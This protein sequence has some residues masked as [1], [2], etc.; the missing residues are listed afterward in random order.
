MISFHMRPDPDQSRSVPYSQ[1]APGRGTGTSD[2]N[3]MRTRAVLARRGRRKGI[4]P[5]SIP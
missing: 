1:Y 2:P 5:L 3:S 4:R